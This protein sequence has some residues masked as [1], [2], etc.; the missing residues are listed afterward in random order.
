M[1]KYLYISLTL[2]LLVVGIISSY[3]LIPSV[4]SFIN[5]LFIRETPVSEEILLEN[6]TEPVNLLDTYPDLEIK[7]SDNFKTFKVGE[8]TLRLNSEFQ[9]SESPSKINLSI[10]DTYQID[11]FIYPL[12]SQPRSDVDTS[13]FE[14]V[15]L[16]YK[17]Q[18]AQKSNID[19]D[20]V[21]QILS[22]GIGSQVTDKLGGE[23]LTYTASDLLFTDSRNQIAYLLTSSDSQRY[24]VIVLDRRKLYIFNIKVDEENY[25][26]MLKTFNNMEFEK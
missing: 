17:Y 8:L 25:N 21:G 2:G 24:K 22:F 9:I 16:K 1:S 23:E 15:L 5:S 18:L 4:S 12:S 19:S 14:S 26:K 20:F 10:K 3:F 13:N 11:V 7:T 6:L